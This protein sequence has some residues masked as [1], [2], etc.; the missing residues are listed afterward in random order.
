M[1]DRDDRAKP[2]QTDSISPFRMV[3]SF[4]RHRDLL[5]QLV[6]R[7]VKIS[8]SG[9][10]LGIFWA[11]ARPLLLL[12][13]YT[14]VFGSIFR[15]RFYGAQSGGTIE[16]A[17]VLLVG[18]SIFTIFADMLGRS[19]AL[20][21]GNANLVK[22]VVFPLDLLIVA[23]LGAVLFHFALSMA[24]F[25]VFFAL[26]RG[27]V[28]L[29][30]LVAPV[31]LIPFLGLTLGVAWFVSATAVFFRDIGQMT[32][33]L[34]SV[35]MF[36][37]P[38]FFPISAVPEAVRGLISLNPISYYVETMRELFFSGITPAP[39]ELFVHYLI[40]FTVMWLGWAWFQVTRRGFADVL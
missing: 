37:C 34:I 23:E 21:V 4:W 19:P 5:W 7:Q 28:P 36:M 9:S 24:V 29:A 17:L 13:V 26:Y 6:Q 22:K 32:G 10:F 1:T 39:A 25:L 40:G 3:K 11:L 8:Y 2:N 38:I 16:F 33:I 35:L 18:L 27:G 14:F 30:A 31:I 15:V 20:I 12:G